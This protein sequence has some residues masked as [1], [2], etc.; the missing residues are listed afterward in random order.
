LLLDIARAD[1]WR[2]QGLVSRAL[3]VL[4]GPETDIRSAVRVAAEFFRLTW[5]EV[6]LPQQREVLWTAVLDALSLGRPPGSVAPL[7]RPAL[8]QQFALAPFAEDAAVRTL[9]AW[10]Q[11]RVR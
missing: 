4:G 10:Q 2:P 11:L 8:R 5:F 3:A 9:A 7:L 6:L 1:E